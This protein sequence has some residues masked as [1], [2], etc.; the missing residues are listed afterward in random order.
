MIIFQ[1]TPFSVDD[2]FSGNSGTF[3]LCTQDT[4]Q[5]SLLIHCSLSSLGLSYNTHAHNEEHQLS[6]DMVSFGLHFLVMMMMMM[7]QAGAL[8]TLL[9][10]GSMSQ[11]LAACVALPPAHNRHTISNW[12]FNL[13]RVCCFPTA[14]YTEVCLPLPLTCE[15]RKV[16]CWLLVT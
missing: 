14:H 2:C 16:D 13:L 5:C 9:Y 12:G 7:I 8:S 10:S 11:L 6:T 15:N 3:L 4:C 1:V